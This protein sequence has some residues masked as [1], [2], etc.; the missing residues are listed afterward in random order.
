MGSAGFDF[1]ENTLLVPHHRHRHKGRDLHGPTA[2][3]PRTVRPRLLS[4]Q[5]LPRSSRATF[6][7]CRFATASITKP[8]FLPA[9]TA[10]VR[11]HCGLRWR[12]WYAELC[13]GHLHS[14][15][16][17]NVVAAGMANGSAIVKV[18]AGAGTAER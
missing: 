11:G 6:H 3:S 12:R 14:G 5:A 7:G 13:P 10:T 15:G 1:Y 9:R 4:L 17:Q 8:R 2:Q 18:G 16:R